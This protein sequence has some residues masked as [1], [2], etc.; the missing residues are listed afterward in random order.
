MLRQASMHEPLRPARER[1]LWLPSL[2]ENVPLFALPEPLPCVPRHHK[3]G[4]PHDGGTNRNAGPQTGF[5][6]TDQNEFDLT[7]NRYLR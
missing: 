7:C 4:Q 6:Q 3:T 2:P 5:I 1:L